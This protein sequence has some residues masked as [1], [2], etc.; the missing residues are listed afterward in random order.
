VETTYHGV[1]IRISIGSMQVLDLLSMVSFLTQAYILCK[2]PTMLCGFFLLHCAGH[3]SKVYSGMV[4]ATWN[5]TQQMVHAV[6]HM[7]CSSIFFDN[8]AGADGCITLETL[9]QKLAHSLHGNSQLDEIELRGLSFFCLKAARNIEQHRYSKPVA[10]VKRTAIKYM[11]K[12]ISRMRGTNSTSGSDNGSVPD[13]HHVSNSSIK[14]EDSENAVLDM[15][16]FMMSMCV[17]GDM[18]VRDVLQVFDV[19]RKRGFVE[20]FLLSN[21]IREEL[22]YVQKLR[23]PCEASQMRVSHLHADEWQDKGPMC[24]QNRGG[25]IDSQPDTFDGEKT[26]G[27]ARTTHLHA[28]ELQNNGLSVC[29]GRRGMMDSQPDNFDDEKTTGSARTLDLHADE[30]QIKG[31]P[32]CE[33]R[34]GVIDSEAEKPDSEKTAGSDRIELRIG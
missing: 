32:V 18:S 27:S 13:C 19:D 31:P 15:N 10:H 25:M 3:L 7:V 26:T 22:E 9:R 2:V 24:F 14:N 1:Q 20:Q 34:R 5:V 23:R 33:G 8:L 30:L 29:E 4:F 17:T 6:M 21:F 12:Y 28:D 16:Q 11:S